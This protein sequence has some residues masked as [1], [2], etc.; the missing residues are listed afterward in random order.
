MAKNLTRALFLDQLIFART[1]ICFPFDTLNLHNSAAFRAN[2]GQY[3]YPYENSLLRMHVLS[4]WSWEI[5]AAL[6]EL[7]V[8]NNFRDMTQLS[9]D[10]LYDW[11]ILDCQSCRDSCDSPDLGL[12]GRSGF[13]IIR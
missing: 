12:S 13:W 4:L 5:W 11:Q 10:R 6:T 8:F 3:S 2:S 1:L 9:D 7:K